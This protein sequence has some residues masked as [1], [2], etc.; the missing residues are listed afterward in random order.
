M[1]I[2]TQTAL[3]KNLHPLRQSMSSPKRTHERKI[4]AIKQHMCTRDNEGRTYA[5]KREKSTSPA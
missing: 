3:L 5:E 2:Y 1:H 4:L